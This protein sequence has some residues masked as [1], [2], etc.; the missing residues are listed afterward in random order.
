[1]LSPVIFKIVV[2]SVVRADLLEVC[3]LQKAQHGFGSAAGEHS[4]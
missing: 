2:D 1:M 3:R 4:I